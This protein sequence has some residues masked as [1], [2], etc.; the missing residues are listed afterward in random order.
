VAALEPRVGHGVAAGAVAG[1]SGH[2]KSWV[3]S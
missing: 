1:S 2:Q 3:L